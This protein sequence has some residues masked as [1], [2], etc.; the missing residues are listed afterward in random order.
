MY[1]KRAGACK[2]VV[3]MGIVRSTA[4]GWRRL[5]A[6]EPRRAKGVLEDGPEGPEGP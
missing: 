1:D 4:Y 3:L 5:R 6:V 2:L